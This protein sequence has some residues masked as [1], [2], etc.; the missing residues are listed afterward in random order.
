MVWTGRVS[1]CIARS[2]VVGSDVRRFLG[3]GEAMVLWAF[4]FRKPLSS[5]IR[6]KA[7]LQ[8][9]SLQLH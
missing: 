5:C 4:S 2:L 9:G 6:N 8:S 7:K 1:A 3:P